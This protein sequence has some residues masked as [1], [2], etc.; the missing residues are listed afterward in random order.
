MSGAPKEHD[1]C[2]ADIRLWIRIGGNGKILAY[3][4]EPRR[5][6]MGPYLLP[7]KIPKEVLEERARMTG[8]TKTKSGRVKGGG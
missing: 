8:A 2:N 4:E 5:P 3:T 6:C 7:I 1:V